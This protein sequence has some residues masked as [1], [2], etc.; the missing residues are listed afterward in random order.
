MAEILVYVLIAVC[1]LAAIMA[2]VAVVKI[3]GLSGELANVS[4]EL[5]NANS[6]LASVKE[7]RDKSIEQAHQLEEIRQQNRELAAQTQANLQGFGEMIS[8]N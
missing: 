2:I 7:L 3:S 1:L 8:R 5:A 6:E 4:S